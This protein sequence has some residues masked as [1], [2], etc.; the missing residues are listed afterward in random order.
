MKH[1]GYGVVHNEIMQ[2]Q[3]LVGIELAVRRKATGSR[4]DFQRNDYVDLH[5]KTRLTTS[6]TNMT[7]H[8]MKLSGSGKAI[9]NCG[10]KRLNQPPKLKFVQDVGIP[11]QGP[12]IK[13]VHHNGVKKGHYQSQCRRKIG[14]GV[15][16][17]QFVANNVFLH[18]YC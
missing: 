13:S 3:I 12:A 2:D 8:S 7:G 10:S 4:T 16:S 15:K 17:I 6:K 11:T 18:G 5:V 1:C 14:S 9:K